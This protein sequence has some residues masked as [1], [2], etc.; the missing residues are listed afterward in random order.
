MARRT[1]WASGVMGG[2]VSATLLAIFF[3]PA[4]FVVIRRC[5]KYKW[6]KGCLGAFIISSETHK[7]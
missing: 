5:F 7:N 3:V 4:F 2:M 1:L 6:H